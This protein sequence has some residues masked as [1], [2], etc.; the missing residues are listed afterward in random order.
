MEDFVTLYLKRIDVGQILDGLHERMLVWRAT[1]E[2]LETGYPQSADYTE[3]CSS[4]LEALAI[5]DYYQYIIDTI[6]KQLME[7]ENNDTEKTG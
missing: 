2:Y 7:Q 6:E 1:N 5:A 3:E 4:P